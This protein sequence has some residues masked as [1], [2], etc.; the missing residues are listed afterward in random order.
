MKSTY[1]AISILL[2]LQKNYATQTEGK[3][4]SQETSLSSSKLADLISLVL[5]ED[6]DQG[7]HLL[8]LAKL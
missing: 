7:E 2:L 6:C 1:L 8:N 3:D 5:C 4:M